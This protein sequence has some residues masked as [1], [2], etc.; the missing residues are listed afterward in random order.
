[1]ASDRTD[2]PPSSSASSPSG[3]GAQLAAL[4]RELNGLLGQDQRTIAYDFFAM[5]VRATRV[6]SGRLFLSTEA[7][8]PEYCLI[9]ANGVLEEL[10]ES[11]AA[12]LL[13]Q[14]LAGW[15]Y[16]QR[17]GTVI[18]DL[19]KNPRWSSW[20][21][22]P[23]TATSGSV[24]AVPLLTGGQPIGALALIAE[25]AN[26]FS[27]GDLSI[28]GNVAAQASILIE[29]ARL[30]SLV[31]RQ[32]SAIENL[33]R[34]ARSI[35]TVQELSQLLD[36]ILGQLVQTVPYPYALILLQEGNRLRRAAEAGFP[37]V[38]HQPA[39]EFSPT[40]IRA[41]FRALGRQATV[42]S[43]E[44]EALAD[45][46][47]LGF[48]DPIRGWAIA[49]LI[50]SGDVIGVLLL[51][52]PAARARGEHYTPT[53]DAFADHIALAV[54]NHQLT[55]ATERRLRELA[56]LNETGQAITSTL[57]LDQILQLLLERVRELLEIDAV[58]VALRDDQTQDLVFEAASGEGAADVIGMRL[59]P[60][61]GIAG[62]VAETGK[63]LVVQ[64]VY[65]DTRFF[66]EID[67]LT[68]MQ[69]Q[70]ILCMPILLKGRVVGVIE[71]LNP[72]QIPFDEQAI[73][74]LNAL[75]GLAATAIENARLFAQ[76]HSA[77]A[78]YERLFEDST[79]PIIITDLTGTIVQ[80]NRMACALLA[81]SKETLRGM[82]L[83]HFR[84]AAGE[85]AFVAPM[86]EIQANDET[87]FQTALPLGRQRITV[88][89]KA[90]KVR[91]KDTALI[92]W[93]GR[94]ISAQVELEQ[95]RE[96]MVRMMVHDLRNPLANIMNS[97]DVL[98][99]VIAEKEAGIS[100]DELL[101]IA[102]RS[103]TRMQQLI[104]SILDISRLETGQAILSTQP[105][106]LE[107]LLCDAIAFIEPQAEIRD[108]SLTTRVAPNL[109]KVEIDSDMILRVVLN[110]LDNACKFTQMEGSVSLT[111]VAGEDIVEVKVE[112]DGPG[113]HPDH[114]DSIFEKFTRLRHQDEPK[115]TGLG[116]TFC[117]LAVEAHEGQIWAESELGH[118]T[119]I[120]FTLP[121]YS[122]TP[123]ET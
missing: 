110:V 5:M 55:R 63:P 115:G 24:L 29:N 74:L 93:I 16:R 113:I 107:P 61:Q 30:R 59:K 45:L 47:T 99:D 57:D 33:R 53:I 19:A 7:D 21:E 26:H 9:L 70:A 66:P 117:K 18:P 51:A 67:Q 75:A 121:L 78:R 46:E 65:H 119:T 41:I 12:P 14:G 38:E 60:G 112:D 42:V 118:G 92:Q 86:E 2:S 28:A 1:M 100:S 69:T 39:R 20:A 22:F 80:V 34:A 50:A 13:K 4:H 122:P 36:T 3:H 97:L 111:A 105:T 49:P 54:A 76:V 11:T 17:R 91:I 32:R 43:S 102:K 35:S 114:L 98:R 68:G 27:E 89:F 106:D 85:R 40:D 79:H 96:D 6:N 94:D 101:K 83:T 73:D 25:H 104:S 58:S 62:W 116:L 10:D 103:G 52:S 8:K 64:D 84:A 44:G 56:F 31:T 37:K 90:T 81:G 123:N 88:E 77:E 71:A 108:I 23:E 120:R 87:T 82:N 72:N 15:A 48:P 95:I 109:P